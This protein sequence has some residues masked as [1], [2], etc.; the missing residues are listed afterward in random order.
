MLYFMVLICSRL[1]IFIHDKNIAKKAI[2]RILF[3]T[4]F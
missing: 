1:H 3:S 4:L 2:C